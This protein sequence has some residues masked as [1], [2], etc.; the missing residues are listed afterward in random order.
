MF[1]IIRCFK[2][3]FLRKAIMGC[4]ML[5][6]SLKL[7]SVLNMCQCLF[8]ISFMFGSTG[9]YVTENGTES[10]CLDFQCFKS[11]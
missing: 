5:N 1:V 9:F 7:L 3:V 2:L 8:I 6:I 4:M 11:N 10:L